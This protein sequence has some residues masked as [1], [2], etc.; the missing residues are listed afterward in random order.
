[1]EH[2]ISQDNFKENSCKSL[3]IS[4]VKIPYWWDRKVSS[5]AATLCAVRPDLFD[6]PVVGDV[7]P[8][9]EPSITSKAVVEHKTARKRIMTATVWEEGKDPTGW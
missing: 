4:L 8:I 7:I 5:L 9:S 2:R 3:G 1:M 6:I